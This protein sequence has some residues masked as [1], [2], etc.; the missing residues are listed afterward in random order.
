MV[1]REGLALTLTG[2]ICGLVAAAF[3]TRLLGGM[4]FGVSATDPATFAAVAA[5]I[6][7]IGVSACYLPARRAVHADPLVTLKAS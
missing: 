1:V 7:L 2:V 5:G 3:L 4:L 6:V